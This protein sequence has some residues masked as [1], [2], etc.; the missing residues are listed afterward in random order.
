MTILKVALAVLALSAL[1]GAL[2]LFK[3]R[4]L[5]PPR[6]PAKSIYVIGWAR[7]NEELTMKRIAE[8]LESAFK[9][10]A[11][12]EGFEL[13]IELPHTHRVIGK[14][15]SELQVVVTIYPKTQAQVVSDRLVI[16]IKPSRKEAPILVVSSIK[17]TPLSFTQDS[18]GEVIAEGYAYMVK[19]R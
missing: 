11:E 19:I 10:M 16:D 12:R 8:R 13:S 18:L 5:P 6:P 3:K 2:L 9:Q 4:I 14:Q 1:P 17:T 15:K 7:K